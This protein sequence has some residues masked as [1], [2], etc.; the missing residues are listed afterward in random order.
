DIK[1][2][3]GAEVFVLR[4]NSYPIIYLRDIFGYKHIEKEIEKV[5]L[6]SNNEKSLALVVDDFIGEQEIVIKSLSKHL[7]SPSYVTGVTKLG[8]GR[9]PIIIDVLGIL[10]N[11]GRREDKK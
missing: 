7:Y 5:V 11:Y 4:G 6:V 9:I 1:I 3:N 8:D 10:N 2:V